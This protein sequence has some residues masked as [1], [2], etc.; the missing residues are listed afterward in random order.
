[1]DA[2]FVANRDMYMLFFRKSDYLECAVLLCLVV[3]LT[4]LASSFLLSSLS[5][6]Q[7]SVLCTCISMCMNY[8][9]HYYNVGLRTQNKER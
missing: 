6:K 5:L 4:L 1:M 8:I 3:C 2:C 9:A 7:A